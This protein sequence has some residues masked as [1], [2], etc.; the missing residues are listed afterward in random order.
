MAPLFPPPKKNTYILFGRGATN[1]RPNPRLFTCLSKE[2]SEVNNSR[3]VKRIA[4]FSSENHRRDGDGMPCGTNGTWQFFVTFLGWL[5]DPSKGLSDLQIGIKSHVES[6]GI[7]YVPQMLHVMY[8]I[9]IPTKLP[10]KNKPNVL[11]R[12]YIRPE[13]IGY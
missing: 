6:P 9:F 3:D 5:S 11:N 8:G 2:L 7:F 12:Y 10:A 1:Q 4:R 13:H